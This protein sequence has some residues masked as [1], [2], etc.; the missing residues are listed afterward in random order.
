MEIK[1]IT[2]QD[3]KKLRENSIAVIGTKEVNEIPENKYQERKNARNIKSFLKRWV[4]DN[5]EFVL[6]K[7]KSGYDFITC[8]L[9]YVLL[10]DNEIILLD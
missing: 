2:S 8:D 3:V 1:K 5:W 7:L 4:G 9:G 6:E 10:K